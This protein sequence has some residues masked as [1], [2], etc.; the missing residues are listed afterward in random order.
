MSLIN[1]HAVDN[2]LTLVLKRHSWISTWF[3][4]TAFGTKISSI[5]CLW[6]TQNFINLFFVIKLSSYLLLS[7]FIHHQILHF[8]CVCPLCH[9]G[10]NQWWHHLSSIMWVKSSITVTDVTHQILHSHQS[11]LNNSVFC[12]KG[13]VWLV[14][15]SG[16]YYMLK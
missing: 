6:T 5:T 7:M 14:L 16:V 11:T 2:F 9:N 8:L 1:N 10:K 3:I 13:F 12:I 4:E 15:L